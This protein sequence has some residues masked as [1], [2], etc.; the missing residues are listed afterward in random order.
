MDALKTVISTRS[1]N[2]PITKRLYRGDDRGT[3]VDNLMSAII[4][5]SDGS[6]TERGVF[7]GRTTVVTDLRGIRTHLEDGGIAYTVRTMRGA[8]CVRSIYHLEK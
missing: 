6:D 8:G 4:D 2:S 3:A 7:D 1:D 5:D